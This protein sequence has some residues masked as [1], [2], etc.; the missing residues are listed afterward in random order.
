MQ[1]VELTPPESDEALVERTRRGERTAEGDLVRR[2]YPGVHA[3][4]ARL[5]RDSEGARDATQEAFL[6]A[7]SRLEQYD[8]RHKFSA[9]IFRI[10]VNLIRD[11][12]R[13]PGRVVVAELA[14]DDWPAPQPP[15]PDAVIR[16]EDV[17]RARRIMEELPHETR[18][19]VLLHFQEGFNGREVAYSLDL[20]PLAARI[21]ICRGVAF[22][23]ARL[24]EER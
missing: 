21:R 8:G 17:Q 2:L 1:Q 4:A 23:R 10:L 19:A 22:I 13:R 6:R 14:P 20:T 15:A 18:L 16:E 3:L 24:A 7:F 12:L 9:W 11:D 5:L